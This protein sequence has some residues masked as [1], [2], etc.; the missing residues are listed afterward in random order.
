LGEA[1]TSQD[2][3]IKRSIKDMR[4]TVLAED[5]RHWRATSISIS[6]PWGGTSLA[7]PSPAQVISEITKEISRKIADRYVRDLS[8]KTVETAV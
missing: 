1:V 7:N 5:T 8:T 2:D 6:P 3:I 4:S